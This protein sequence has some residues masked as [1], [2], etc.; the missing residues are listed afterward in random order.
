MTY[1]RDD[2]DQPVEDYDL[3]STETIS[4]LL[5]QMKSAGGF[6]AT[7]LIDARDILQNAISE[8][9]SGNEDK[10]VLNWLSFPAC[11]MATG[12]RGFFHEAVRSRAYNVIS[13]TCGTLDHDIART[14]RDYYHG[15]FDLDDVLLGNVGLNRLGNVIV[16]N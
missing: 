7:K 11:L 1:D 3:R 15:S 10:K 4:D 13:T 9:K 16:P 12:T 6:T 14:F 8:T 2:F 5:R